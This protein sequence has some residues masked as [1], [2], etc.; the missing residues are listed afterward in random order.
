[1]RAATVKNNKTTETLMPTTAAA[2]VK[3]TEAFVANGN[4]P[5]VDS[6]VIGR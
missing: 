3:D 1:M 4:M 5:Q 6:Q 2:V